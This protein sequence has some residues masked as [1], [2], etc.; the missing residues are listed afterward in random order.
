MY[1]TADS[2]LSGKQSADEI[3]EA[4]TN[5]VLD[6]L[7]FAGGDKVAVLVNG[8]GATP[9]EELYLLFRKAHEIIEGRAWTERVGTSSVTT[10]FELHGLDSSG[11]DNLRAEMALVHVHVDLASG[12]A[13]PVPEFARTLLLG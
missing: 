11:S 7:P 9:P 1:Q 6:D 4:I 13:L 2:N 5:R 8:L 12:K 10:R 3:A